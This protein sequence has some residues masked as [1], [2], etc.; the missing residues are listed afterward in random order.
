MKNT[1]KLVVI[2]ILAT[3]G[4]IAQIFYGTRY[5]WLI[6]MLMYVII[7]IGL[8][9]TYHRYLS[10]KSFEFKYDW[11]RKAWII[12]CAVGSG[13]SS[14]VAWVAI[15]REH[16]RF[17]DTDKDRHLGTK[18]RYLP[19]LHLKSMLI[20]PRLKYAI[21]IARDPWCNFLH[22]HYFKLHILWATFLFVISP[23]LLISAYLVP[24]SLLWHSG[25]LVNSISHLY[26]YRN[27]ETHDNSKNNWLVASIFFGEWHNNHH[28]HPGSAKHGYKWWEIDIT[29]YAICLFGK[30][31][32][33]IK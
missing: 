25:N 32:R 29:Y 3:I 21:D 27:F 15:H 23:W 6:T 33:M 10:H 14:P 8:S 7:A 11:L 5:D 9:M 22:E 4:L 30:N 26:G 31:I 16:H 12:I 13:F 19:G 28:A 1:H 18:L 24:V 2:H 17:T 20:E